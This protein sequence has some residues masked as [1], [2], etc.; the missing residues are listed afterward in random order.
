[1]SAANFTQ[2]LTALGAYESGIDTTKV[3]TADWMQYLRVFD[4]RYGNV[5]PTSVSLS[6]TQDLIMLQYHV[7]NTLGFLG[8]YQFGEAL[9]IDLGYYVPAASGYYGTTSTNEWKGAWTGKNGVHSKA[10][11]MTSV[12]EL[13]IREAFAMNVGV[14]NTYLAQAGKTIDDYI[15]HQFTYTRLG[16][17]HVATVTMS[18]ILAG[19]HLQGPTGVA[20]LF[21]HNIQS[22]DEYGTNILFYIDKYGGYNTPFGTAANDTLVGSD[23]SETFMGAGGH[24][25]YT[26][27]A[28]L[29]KIIITKGLGGI[30][31]IT[32]FDVKNDVI[33]LSNFAG[34]AFKDLVITNV[35]GHAVV[36][37]PNGQTINIMNHTAAE[38]GVQQFVYG[39]YKITWN[40]NSGDTLINSFNIK[41]DLIDLS[42]APFQ[43]RSATVV[44][45]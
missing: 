33:S 30:D 31:T 42:Y 5:N 32:D 10:D 16:E 1:M 38:I 6:N 11:F 23:Y 21:L 17:T 44:I 22:S 13:A 24:D 3:Q 35:S 18:G 27:G 19:A 12:Q 8:K 26:T 39:P 7:H 36:K 29:D 40:A 14:I 20:Q 15:G 43:P 28:G 4:P 9:L 2:F 37:F 41:Y 25:T 45:N 34:V